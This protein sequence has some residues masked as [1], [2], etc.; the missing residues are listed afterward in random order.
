[1]PTTEANER[2]RGRR[3]AAR[4]GSRRAS[5]PG[6]RRRCWGAMPN[7]WSGS[8]AVVRRARLGSGSPSSR[9]SRRSLASDGVEADPE[10]PGDRAG[11]DRDQTM[12]KRTTSAQMM[13]ILS[14]AQPAERDLHRRLAGDL[15]GLLAVRDR[16]APVRRSAS[17]ASPAPSPVPTCSPH[18]V[19]VRSVSAG[20]PPAAPR[21]D[22]TLC[23]L[24]PPD[25][26]RRVTIWST[27]RWPVVSR[28]GPGK[29]AGDHSRGG[30][31]FA[32]VGVDTGFL[33]LLRA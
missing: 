12:K 13:A 24:R 19:R 27:T 4:C 10:E 8:N 15:L 33:A 1:M 16:W 7:G 18:R 21:R 11:E 30:T 14:R 5:R 25:D 23:D 28:D 29:P 17:P 2:R 32:G 9:P 22:G 6:C 20:R 3:S 26:H 31:S